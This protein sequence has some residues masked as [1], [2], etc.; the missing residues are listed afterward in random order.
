MYKLIALD[1]DGTLLDKSKRISVENLMFIDKAIQSGYE[2]IIATGRRYYSAKELTS[3]IKSHITILANN[4]NIIR[5]SLDDKILFSKFIEK[6]DLRDVLVEGNILN[7]HPIIHVDYFLEGYDM[8]IEENTFKMNYLPKDEKRYRII[9]KDLIYDV[10]RVLA[11]VYRGEKELLKDFYN[12]LNDKY[13]DR[14]SSHVL[15]NI[16]ISEAMFEVMNPLGSKWKSILEYSRSI[17]IKPDEIIALGDDNND[18]E[19]ILNAGLGIAMKN[20]S[21]LVREAA[22]IIT[23]RDNNNSGVAFELRKILDI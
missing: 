16:D 1:L 9:P 7:L 11:I 17:G 23:E 3:S 4:G 12:N 13:P 5:N 10:D 2:V 6:S 19:M 14:Y 22:N 20:G 18:L 8:I 15:E 21:T